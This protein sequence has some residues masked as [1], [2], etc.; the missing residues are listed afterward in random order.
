MDRFNIKGSGCEIEFSEDG[1]FV[2]F[3]DVLDWI[4]KFRV[5]RTCQYYDSTKR[6]CKNYIPGQ[7]AQYAYV[8]FCEAKFGCNNHY[9][10]NG[11][12]VDMDVFNK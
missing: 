1:D 7:D 6:R 5:C 4:N 8:E 11:Y 3:S 9:F 12:K 10:K 2:A